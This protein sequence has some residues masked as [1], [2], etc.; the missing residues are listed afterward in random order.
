MTVHE[1]ETTVSQLRALNW[2]VRQ[3]LDRL[4][5]LVWFAHEDGGL[6][7]A[8]TDHSPTEAQRAFDAWAAHLRLTPDPPRHRGGLTRLRAQGRADGILVTIQLSPCRVRSL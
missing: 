1:I 4:P 8:P 5:I 7:G 2:L 3:P 6:I